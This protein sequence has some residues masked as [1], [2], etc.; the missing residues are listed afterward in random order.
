MFAPSLRRVAHV[1]KKNV[2]ALVRYMWYLGVCGFC[3]EVWILFCVW[4]WF[5]LLE[6]SGLTAVRGE[7][8]SGVL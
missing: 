2:T 4:W 6:C 5:P 7:G 8:G 1:E 3:S